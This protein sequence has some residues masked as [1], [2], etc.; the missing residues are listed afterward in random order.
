MDQIFYQEL[1]N[2]NVLKISKL[3]TELIKLNDIILSNKQILDF[4]DEYNE[5]VE[6][7]SNEIVFQF[8]SG[9][10]IVTALAAA[11]EY[12]VKSEH[13]YL[14]YFNGNQ[15]NTLCSVPLFEVKNIL[16]RYKSEVVP[17]EA[18]SEQ[19]KEII[20]NGTF[21][22]SDKFILGGVSNA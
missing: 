17:G 8:K 9:E 2:L 16:P 15:F 19:V 10:T 13:W 11:L 4:N 7:M 20:E 6:A 18:V 3:N 12:S 1:S 14:L 21:D 5:I 22:S